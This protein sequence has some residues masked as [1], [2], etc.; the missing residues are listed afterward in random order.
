MQNPKGDKI[1]DFQ[2]Y[3]LDQKKVIILCETG[4]IYDF[5][6]D[7][8]SKSWELVSEISIE[9]I[10]E[11]EEELVAFAVCP[12]GNYSFVEIGQDKK[13]YL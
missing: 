10:K 6:I 3:G 11:R 5:Q 2:L 12:K 4:N 9:L 8:N 7:F 1:L 13:P